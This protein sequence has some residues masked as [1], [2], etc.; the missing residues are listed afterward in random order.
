MK[1]LTGL[2]PSA[3]LKITEE[4]K[5]P[6]L[7]LERLVQELEA[8]STPAYISHYRQDVSGGLDEQRIRLVEN[9]LKQFLK[10][11]DLRIA[12]LSSASRQGRLTPELREQCES[13]TD[14]WEL[15]DLYLPFKQKQES[16]ADTARKQGLEGLASRLEAQ[17]PED[18]DVKALAAEYL[19]EKAGIKT[20]A[21]A[22]R[23]A[24]E[25]IAQS[26]SED[27]TVRRGL[28]RLLRQRARLVVHDGQSVRGAA[29]GKYK[30]LLGYQARCNK[31]AWRQMM[32]LRRAVHEI[33]LR[34][35][36]RLPANKAVSFLLE[37][38]GARGSP[39]VQ[40]QLGAVAA[41]AFEGYIARSFAKE[42]LQVLN[43][44]CDREAVEA[45]QKNLRK[46]LM[47]PPAGRIGV[48]GLETGRPGGWRAA[49][50]NPDGEFVEGA[51]IHRDGGLQG[52]PAEKPP[53][54][55]ESE[56]GDA[57]TASGGPA[58]EKTR[59]TPP[60]KSSSTT[61]SQN[62]NP[63][64]KQEAQPGDQPDQP[65]ATNGSA[66]AAAPASLEA[67]SESI[68]PVDDQPASTAD[69]ATDRSSEEPVP[70]SLPGKPLASSNGDGSRESVAPLV[71]LLRRN[72]V[73]AIVMATGPGVR[74]VERFV[75]SSIREAGCKDIFWT[76]VNE[77]G[78]WIYATSKAARRDI[79]NASMA[80]RGAACLA[81]RLQDPLAAFA[82]VDPRTLGL[83]QFHQSIDAHK[84]REGLR[85]TLESTVH[86]VG[87][88][89]NTAPVDLIALAPG[90]TDRLAK[91]VV[92]HRQKKGRFTKREQLNA[93]SGLSKRI[94]KQVVGF[95]RVFEGEIPLDATGIHPDQYPIAERI[96][97]AAGVSESEALEKPEVLDSVV[98]EEYQ[99]PE[100]PLAVL[101][102]IVQQL[103][104]SVRNP[105]GDFVRPSRE[106]KLRT[107]EELAIGKKV[108]GV[109]TNIAAF[110]AFVDIGADQDGLVHISRMSDKFVKDPNAAVK[111]GDRVEVYVLALE[112]GGKRISLSMRDPA[113]AAAQRPGRTRVDARK[114]SNAPRRRRQKEPRREA[115]VTRRSFGPSGKEKLRQERDMKKLSLDEKL[116]LLQTKY[117]TK[118]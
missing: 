12:V 21:D 112:D 46:I 89:L 53:V 48:V 81:K 84:L 117:R 13:A 16:P 90:M 49:V 74:H 80:Q 109:V 34:F 82:H 113:A 59:S 107:D 19:N 62:G 2:P 93:V 50:I 30:N 55:T 45:F 47:T 23:G 94:Y 64:A 4:A 91:R 60:E 73:N 87:I 86:I 111:V 92:E 98:L 96:L 88:D 110:G 102:G 115:K 9:R 100:F 5:I 35:E 41:R 37:T 38:K 40:L 32:A 79:P 63:A 51:V 15:E 58:E 66:S 56:K 52:V 1:S 11:E 72:E 54:L 68:E 18:Q 36:I 65:A 39:Q 42:E 28:R 57:E 75:R 104:P 106:V 70:K 97:A 101:Q 31:V 26:W 33:G 114:A 6:L 83:G 8:G 25:I 105:R 103:R 108:E 20:A 77:A 118:V 29:K 43:E 44:R 10:L 27:V 7:V 61:Q 3:Y 22:L 116:A 71:E 78:S 85:T 17:K 24:R 67:G 95:T 76:T 99:S 14:R 69:S